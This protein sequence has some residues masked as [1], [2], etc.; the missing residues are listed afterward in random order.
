MPFE[1]LTDSLNG[2]RLI[3]A[4]LFGGFVLAGLVAYSVLAF[5]G[6]R[7]NAQHS[8]QRLA[9]AVL[10]SQAFLAAVFL[11]FLGLFLGLATLPDAEAWRDQIGQ[12]GTVGLVVIGARGTTNVLAAILGWYAAVVAPTTSTTFDDTVLPILRR[13]VSVIIAGVALLIVLDTLGV[14]IS[15]LLGGLGISGLAVA[16]ALQP[17]LANTFAGAYVLSEGMISVGDYI[18]LQG[19]P[20]GYVVSIGWRSTKIRT[21]L[22]NYV[23][24]P[25]SVM[26]DTILTNYSGP[27]PKMNILVTCGVSYASDLGRVNEVA[28]DVARETIA[29]NEAAVKSVEP[30]FGFDRFADSN[31]EF[32]VFLQANDR[33]G[34]FI[35][36]NDFIKRLHTRFLAEGIEINYPVRKLVYEDGLP[37]EIAARQAAS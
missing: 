24:I 30:W 37:P 14:S 33:I 22:N 19:G 36:M 16:L 29:A 3:A 1:S 13:F 26:S 18:E 27:D 32:W 31:I 11:S 12:W 7:L 10:R 6:R 35:V 28:L 25:N 34:S 2:Q 21:W 23:I 8:H 17:T 9:A 20:A 15:P 5:I 4:G